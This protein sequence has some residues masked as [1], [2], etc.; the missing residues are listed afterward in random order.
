MKLHPRRVAAIGCLLV[1]IAVLPGAWNGGPAAEEAH[2]ATARPCPP[3][4]TA[5]VAA[6]N[7]VRVFQR[8]GGNI[9]ACY[10][11]SRRYTDLGL[12]P[13]VGFPDVELPPRLRTAGRFVGYFYGIAGRSGTG[14]EVRVLDAR[15]R[16]WIRL[17]REG[18][19]DGRLTGSRSVEVS[20]LELRRTGSVAWISEVFVAG[21]PGST[22]EV[23]R[24]ASRSSRSRGRSELLDSGPDILPSSLTLS[25][26][27]ISWQKGEERRVAALP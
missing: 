1:A 12:P 25:G 15:S 10:R 16:R 3:A 19:P 26:T 13:E 5:V 21:F 24:A 8:G 22:F 20:D 6:A 11:G 14:G 23:R 9:Y 27:E 18:D 7:R 2:G 17:I 4:N